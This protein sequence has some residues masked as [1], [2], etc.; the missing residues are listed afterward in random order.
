MINQQTIAFI[1]AGKMS[2]A[3]AVGLIKSGRYISN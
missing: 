3:I 1:G 2:T